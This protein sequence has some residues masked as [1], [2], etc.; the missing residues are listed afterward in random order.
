MREFK[1]I[2]S[3]TSAEQL[4]KRLKPEELEQFGDPFTPEVVYD[5]IRKTKHFSSMIVRRPMWPKQAGPGPLDA[6]S[7]CSAGINKTPKSSWVSFSRVF[8]SSALR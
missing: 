4:R 5:A 7:C 3:A 8:I 2:D 1:V 6:N